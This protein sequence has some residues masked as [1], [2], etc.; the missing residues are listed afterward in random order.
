[1]N[2]LISIKQARK[3]KG[4]SLDEL[5]NT[6]KIDKSIIE[7]LEGD[8]ELPKKFKSYKQSYKNSI[9]RYLGYIIDHTVNL[10]KLT[11]DNT[12]LILVIFF[13]LFSFCI[14]VSLS[15]NIY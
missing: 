6:L 1:M 11:E 9:Y 8:R 10:K 14:L 12:K 2:N 13:F 3:A 15:I 5:S 4:I 7:C